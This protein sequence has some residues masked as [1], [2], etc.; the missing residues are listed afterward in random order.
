[1][2]C[3]SV[4]WPTKRAVSGCG[5]GT[6]K[7]WNLF[8]ACDCQSTMICPGQLLRSMVVSWSS[9][10]VLCGYGAGA[11]RLWDLAA[12]TL[13]SEFPGHTD[14]FHPVWCLAVDWEEQCGLSGGG[15]GLLK[16][17]DLR[18]G[19]CVESLPAL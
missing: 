19:A 5:D 16:L 11:I 18:R 13:L 14:G 3:V 10:Q 8:G 15:D 12:G 9:M 17:W 4:D 7:V 2:G 1:M 6:L